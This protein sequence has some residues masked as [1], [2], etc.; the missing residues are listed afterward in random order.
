MASMTNTEIFYTKNQTQTLLFNKADKVNTYLE[1]EVDAFLR[2]KQPLV[3][4]DDLT[5]S[6]TAGLDTAIRSKQNTLA[7]ENSITI[8]QVATLE[9]ILGGLTNKTAVYT[10]SEVNALL[11][12]KNNVIVADSVEMTAVNGLG[13]S[14]RTHSSATAAVD[15][16]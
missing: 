14:F 7:N 9:T 10:Q 16:K 3:G 5:I 13:P 15:T 4:I 1:S 8:K 2:D 11:A 12:A 6:M